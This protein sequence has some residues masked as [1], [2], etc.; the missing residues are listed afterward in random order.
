[1][2][3]LQSLGELLDAVIVGLDPCYALYGFIGG[4]IL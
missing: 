1:M 2:H 3:S 4:G